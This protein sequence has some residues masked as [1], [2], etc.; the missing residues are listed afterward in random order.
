MPAQVFDDLFGVGAHMHISTNDSALNGFERHLQLISLHHNLVSVNQSLIHIEDNRLTVL[1]NAN[2]LS[3]SAGIF[4]SATFGFVEW[5][6]FANCFK[7]ASEVLI[8]MQAS[9]VMWFRLLKH[10]MK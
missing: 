8:C 9:V 3:D 10:Y 1:I 4:R 5:I 7:I 2:V 6:F